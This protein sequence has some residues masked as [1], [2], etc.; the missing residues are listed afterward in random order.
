MDAYLKSII[1]ITI[2][3]KNIAISQYSIGRQ[4]ST[5]TTNITLNVF[6]PCTYPYTNSTYGRTNPKPH[7]EYLSSP[8]IAIRM[9]TL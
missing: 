1:K 5:K 4:K 6:S 7:L 3:L 8:N 2:A 9:P